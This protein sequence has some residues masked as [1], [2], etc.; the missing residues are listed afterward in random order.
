MTVQAQQQ[1]CKGLTKIGQQ[2]SRKA[3]EGALYCK[4]HNPTFAKCA[5][6]TKS[7]NPCK[8]LPMKNSK[9]CHNHNK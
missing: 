1:Q 3:S 5:G 6:I 9:F 2:C 4:Q 7:G 8:S